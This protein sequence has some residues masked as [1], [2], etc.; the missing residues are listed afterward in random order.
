MRDVRAL[1]REVLNADPLVALASRLEHLPGAQ[2]RIADVT[3]LAE[4]AIER[5]TG[6]ADRKT[7][8]GEGTH[9]D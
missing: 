8:A 7:G 1:A 6:A 3:D 2:L 5:A 9:R 4:M